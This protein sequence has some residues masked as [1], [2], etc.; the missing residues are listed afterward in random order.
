MSRPALP[1]APA[2]SRVLSGVELL[3]GAA[4]VIGHNVLHVLPNEVPI[5]FVLGLVSTRLRSGRWSAIGLGRPASWRRT[6]V[7]ALAAAV[8]RI[9]AGELVIDP[10]TSHFWP[11]AA[12]PAGIDEVTGNLPVALEYLLLVW[13][14]AAFGEE[15]AYRGY[16]LVRTADL[17]RRSTAALWIAAVVTSILFGFGH[18][19]K[20]PAGILD[21][22]VAGFIL[23]AA[24]IVS[25]RN[26]WACV[27]AHGLIDTYGVMTLY[28]GWS[29]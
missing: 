26:L 28:L 2:G 15:I 24:Y 19:Y 22:G 23:G 27:L 8:L 9:L 1:P 17:G 11:P 6:L 13:S 21:S 4:I 16:L 7:I 3:L 25:G 20:G 18:T 14:F 12:A 29:S 5:L 10:L